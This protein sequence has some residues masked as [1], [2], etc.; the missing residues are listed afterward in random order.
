MRKSVVDVNDIRSYLCEDPGDFL[1]SIL[2]PDEP[3]GEQ[4]PLN[5]R[6]FADFMIAALVGQNLV[7]EAGKEPRFLA[8]DD[9][10]AARL[11][12]FVMNE[13]NFHPSEGQ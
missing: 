11:L 4:Q 12:I 10:F 2:G 6:I 1:A 3:S 7:A 5:A 9:V 8:K 13:E